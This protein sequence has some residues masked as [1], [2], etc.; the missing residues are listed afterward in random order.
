MLGVGRCQARANTPP[1]RACCCLLL[2]IQTWACSDNQGRI[3]DFGL[4][5]GTSAS[6]PAGSRGRGPPEECY[7]MRLKNHLRREKNKSIYRLTL[8]DNVVIMIISS[9]RRSSIMFV[10]KLLGAL[11]HVPR[12]PRGSAPGD[13]EQG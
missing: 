11:G 12:L 9:A 7:V 3:Q 13:S 6:P 5:G 10:K 8:Y 2:L 1:G 4:G